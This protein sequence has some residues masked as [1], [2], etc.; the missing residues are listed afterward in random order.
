MGKGSNGI[1]PPA[2]N[3]PGGNGSYFHGS[4]AF[5]GGGSIGCVGPN[6]AV[7]GLNGGLRL[8]W[9]LNNIGRAFPSTNVGPM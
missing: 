5:G 7:R 4:G 1:K 3:M 9:D 8:I 2:A 6:S